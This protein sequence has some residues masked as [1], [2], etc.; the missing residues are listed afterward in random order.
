MDDPGVAIRELGVEPAY[1]T[2]VVSPI[3]RL[4]PE[5]SRQYCS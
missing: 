4:N 1:V 5:V 3:A 2:Q